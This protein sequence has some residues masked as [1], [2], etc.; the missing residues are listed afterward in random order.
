[1]SATIPNTRMNA[2]HE[3]QYEFRVLATEEIGN[4]LTIRRAQPKTVMD[5]W[6]RLKDMTIEEDFKHFSNYLQEI[7]S[8]S[9]SSRS[10]DVSSRPVFYL[11][12]KA[13]S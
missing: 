5:M 6:G 1:M 7:L 10:S 4:L 8:S 2:A 9:T 3:I 13:R 12:T 11:I